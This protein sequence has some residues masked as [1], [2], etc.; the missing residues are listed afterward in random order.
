ML[1]IHIDN[2]TPRQYPQYATREQLESKAIILCH[3]KAGIETSINSEL[4]QPAIFAAYR[5]VATLPMYEL[6]RVYK[7]CVRVQ[8]VK[9]E[10]TL[11]EQIKL[12]VGKKELALARLRDIDNWLNSQGL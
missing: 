1:Y 7:P 3:T 10:L 9:V 11:Q 4:G 2:A 5:K 6:A 8:L 12:A